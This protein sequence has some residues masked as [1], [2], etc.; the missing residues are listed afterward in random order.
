MYRVVI[1]EASYVDFRCV[2]KLIQ[3]VGVTLSDLTT[4]TI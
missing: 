1:L 3:G 2:C 4:C